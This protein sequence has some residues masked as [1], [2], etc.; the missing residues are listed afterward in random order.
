MRSPVLDFFLIGSGIPRS[1]VLEKVN[2][3]RIN[4]RAR[5]APLS[6]ATPNFG[7]VAEMRTP[8]ESRGGV[9]G[10]PYW[11]GSEGTAGLRLHNQAARK[12]FL[13]PSPAL[14]ECS[15]DGL[16]RCSI[17]VRRRAIL[18][19]PERQGPH[20]RASYR[21]GISLQDP[22]DKFPVTKHVEIVVVPVA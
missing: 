9:P 19:V 17:A 8:P 1:V 5:A 3:T 11:G 12:R 7:T 6:V 2:H 20:P 21:R 22:A 15:H 16:T 4:R 18:V 13:L 10:A 14:G